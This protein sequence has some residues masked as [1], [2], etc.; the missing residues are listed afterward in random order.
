MFANSA[1][2]S[3][4]SAANT[5]SNRSSRRITTGGGDVLDSVRLAFSQHAV[6]PAVFGDI[7]ATARS[8]ATNH[9]I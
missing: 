8:H 9:H 6:N 3:P 7:V 5:A 2:V 1:T 4:K